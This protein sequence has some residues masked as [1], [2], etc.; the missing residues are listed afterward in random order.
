M[1]ESFAHPAPRPLVAS[2]ERRS[3]GFAGRCLRWATATL[4]VATVSISLFFGGAGYVFGPI[5]DVTTAATL[6]LIVPGVL[7]VRR[8]ARERTGAWFSGL[9]LLT[10]V[11]LGV[12]AGGLLALV[13]GVI[14]LNDS[15]V[16]GGIGILPFLAWLAAFGAISLRRGVLT[17]RVGWLSISALAISIIATAVSP[18]LPMNV[19]VFVL[20]LPL[21]A[22][23]AA[24]L[25]VFGTDLR[26][27]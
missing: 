21:L 7:A 15:F 2:E 22:I 3:Y 4:A 1:S 8:L 10:V 9:S 23:F 16:V 20:G 14:T 27:A 26:D 19:L 12:A 17:R 24:W 25:W 6:L 5:N 11:G 18:F 13:A